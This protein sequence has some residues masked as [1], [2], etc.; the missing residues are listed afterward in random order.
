[1]RW[2]VRVRCAYVT[3]LTRGRELKYVVLLFRQMRARTALTR[4]V[5]IGI[6]RALVHHQVRILACVWRCVCFIEQKA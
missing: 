3:A 1:M 5:Q 4:G 2:A 6:G